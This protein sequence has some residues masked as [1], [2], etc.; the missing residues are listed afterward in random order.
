MT[1]PDDVT[2]VLPR[3]HGDPLSAATIRSTPEDFIVIEDLG[4]AFSG[5]GEHVILTIEKRELNTL[6]CCA[7]TCQIRQCKTYG[8]WLCRT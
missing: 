7:N 3:A 4:Y 5:E 1:F 8:S 6:R 2:V